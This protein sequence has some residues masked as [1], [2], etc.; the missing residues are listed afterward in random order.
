MKTII[1]GKTLHTLLFLQGF[2]AISQTFL[3]G[4]FENNTDSIGYDLLNLEFGH[5]MM[6]KA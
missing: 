3:N 5:C 6:G 1:I 2:V 4:N